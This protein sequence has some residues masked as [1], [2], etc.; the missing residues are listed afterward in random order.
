MGFV[1]KMMAFVCE[2]V[3]VVKGFA[4]QK[5]VIATDIMDRDTLVDEPLL[6]QENPGR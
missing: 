6:V 2:E 1:T 5:G 3:M 4:R